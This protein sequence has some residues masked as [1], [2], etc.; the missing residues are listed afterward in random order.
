MKTI[1]KPWIKL[2]ETIDQED[3]DL[4]N[5]LQEVCINEDQTALKLELDYKLGVSSGKGELTVIQNI[6]EFM[7]FDGPE[8]IGYIGICSYGDAGS[9]IEANGMVQ[10]EYRRQGVFN[11]L[12]ELVIAEWRRRNLG[13]MLLLNDR[14][15]RSGEALIKGTG[16]QYKLSEYEMKLKIDK[17]R[18][19]QGQSSKITLRKATNADAYEIARQNKIY[20]NGELQDVK[21]TPNDND[22]GSFEEAEIN[23]KHEGLVLP[24]E[25]EKRGLTIYLAIKDQQ[26]I[27]KVN[28][29]LNSKVGGIYGL[30]V[31]P[32]YRGKGLGRAILLMAIEKLKEAKA[33][34]VMLQVVAENTNALN[35][36]K[37]CGFT[38]T[39]TMDYYEIRL[40]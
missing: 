9:P 2:K 25:E 11:K 23:M 40:E 6:N 12:S 17:L 7:Y 31:L 37:S 5:K 1:Q 20:F 10:P 4:I 38:E 13:S 30:G 22:T 27:G 29:Q 34:E 8:M 18:L 35:L 39:S 36:Y 3:Y 21:S 15:S 32:K 33:D 16:G 19:L 26:I 14:R 28:L 24:E